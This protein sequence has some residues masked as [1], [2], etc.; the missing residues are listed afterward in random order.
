MS[1]RLALALLAIHATLMASAVHAGAAT[2]PQPTRPPATT[3]APR[4][5]PS[6]PIAGQQAGNLSLY[7]KPQSGASLFQARF[8]ATTAPLQARTTDIAPA[9]SAAPSVTRPTIRPSSTDI[10]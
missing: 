9:R 2:R 5:K 4:P 7:T 1:S 8:N 10:R 6:Q 3:I